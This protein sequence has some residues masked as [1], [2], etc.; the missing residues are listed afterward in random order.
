MFAQHLRIQLA[1]ET[2][3][4]SCPLRYLDSFAM[5]SFTGETRFD[6]ILPVADGQL[7]AGFRVPLDELG[8]ALEDWFRRKGYLNAGEKVVISR[9]EN[10]CAAK[11]AAE[12]SAR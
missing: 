3:S 6:E 11:D 12:S 9:L 10:R 4:R 8:A 5:R 2:S 1:G 7:E